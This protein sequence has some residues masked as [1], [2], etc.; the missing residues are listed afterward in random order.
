[1]EYRGLYDDGDNKQEQRYY[2]FGAHFKYNDLVK[3]LK[4][5][6]E[7]QSV[8]KEKNYILNNSSNNNSNNNN[9]N[10]DNENYKEVYN[11]INKQLCQKMTDLIPPNKFIQSRNIKPLIQSLS[12][13][14]TDIVQSQSNKKSMNHNI[15]KKKT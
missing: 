5:L 2:E 15:T 11:Q 12:K 14:L 4:N 13:K 3:A 6:Q 9:I 1:M 8:K 10:E 7:A